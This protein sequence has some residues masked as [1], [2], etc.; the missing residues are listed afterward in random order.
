MT[1][2]HFIIG[3]PL[4]SIPE[5]DLLNVPTN[6]VTRYQLLSQ[7]RQHFWKRWSS[8]YLTQLQNRYKWQESNN[9]IIKINALVLL[10]DKDLLL[11]RWRLARIV[12]IF[13]GK[14][15]RIRVVSVRTSTG[16][17]KRAINKICVLPMDEI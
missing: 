12:E 1:P 6:R 11:L 4:N 9:E 16:I 10:K 14:D 7:M 2:S 5:P 13:P 17:T 8:E 15:N 3:E